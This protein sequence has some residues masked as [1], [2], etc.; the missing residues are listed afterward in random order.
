[1]RNRW[2]FILS[3]ALG[4]PAL[5]LLCSFVFGIFLPN[6]SPPWLGTGAAYKPDG[7]L[8]SAPKTLWDLASLLIIPAV[9][10]AGAIF[11][12]QAVSNAE[13]IKT[14]QQNQETIL[15]DYIDRMS[16]LLTDKNLAKSQKGDP[17]R[18]V[19]R[20]QTRTTIYR[21]SGG[22]KGLV[23]RFL[24]EGGL[25]DLEDTIILTAGLDLRTVNLKRANLNYCNFSHANFIQA[26]LERVQLQNTQCY[27][28]NF[29][30]ANFANADLRNANLS[31][32]NFTKTA[33]PE[34][35]F[36]DAELIKAIFLDADLQGAV[37]HNAKLNGADFRNAD[38]CGARFDKTDVS[39]AKLTN[40][41]YDADTLW[42]E[43]F[44]PQQV[45]AVFKKG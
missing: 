43:G 32:A 35:N 1:M 20:T 13:S 21:L 24:K 38:L 14:E 9:L 27:K 44:D 30:E 33:C 31:R 23:V 7:E 2:L 5:I 29:T 8:L 19:A 10:S 34:V 12:N 16:N 39:G 42:P 25:I 37:F 40:A 15:Q 28:T 18:N 11:Y 26:N 36:R 3:L 17:V 22:R 45:G 4:I 6:W 41:V